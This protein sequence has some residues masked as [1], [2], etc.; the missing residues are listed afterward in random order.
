MKFKSAFENFTTAFIPVFDKS[1]FVIK[2]M[3]FAKGR[4]EKMTQINFY[5]QLAPETEAR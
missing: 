1:S 4:D 5:C 3:E 2:F